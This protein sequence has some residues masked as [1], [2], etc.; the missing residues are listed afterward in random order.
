MWRPLLTHC[1]RLL[2]NSVS[3]ILVQFHSLYFVTN[4]D[5]DKV[6]LTVYTSVNTVEF[7]LFV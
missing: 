5:C 1:R 6:V 4:L 7:V 2:E 3:I